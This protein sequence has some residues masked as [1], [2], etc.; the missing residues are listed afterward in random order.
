M[1]ISSIIIAICTIIGTVISV[2][3][4]ISKKFSRIEDKLDKIG[5]ILNQ[6]IQRLSKIEGYIEGKTQWESKDEK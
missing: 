1:D 4:L 5:L 3:T 6:Q 2:S